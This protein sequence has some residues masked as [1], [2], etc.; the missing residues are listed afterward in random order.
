M[1]AKRILLTGA[2]GFVGSHILDQLLTHGHSVRAVVRSQPKASQILADF[3][4]Y[5]S[6]LDFGIVP[7]IASPG[8]FDHAVVSDAPF[9]IV[10]HTASPFLCTHL[11]LTCSFLSNLLTS[12]R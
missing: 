7:D 10:I 3:P 11:S 9:D 5:G 6:R 12:L 4:S 1:S 8:A 2:N